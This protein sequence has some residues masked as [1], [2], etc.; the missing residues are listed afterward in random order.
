M[1]EQTAKS[2]I[3]NRIK[4]GKPFPKTLPNVPEYQWEGDP[5]QNFIDR[6]TS[7]DGKI[8]K[9]KTKKGVFEWLDEQPLFDRGEHKIYST[10]NEFTGNF[11]EDD[12]T[13]LRNAHK[14]ETCL[15]E[16]LMG[17]GE[18]G[19]IWVTDQS[20]GHA[21]CALLCRRLYILLDSNNVIGGMHEAY[22]KLKL[23][24][25]QY[26]CFFTGPS[27]TADIEAVHITGAQGT[28]AMTVLL[29]NCQ[30]ASIPP[31]IIVNPEADESV[32]TKEEMNEY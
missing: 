25:H 8:I 17:V 20:L 28:L 16:G 9:F 13:D 11:T 27:A 24:E 10:L 15:T 32:W 19:A 4:A 21:V 29:Y 14:I 1:N 23:N 2:N 7:F 5:V 3:I 12:L 6:L 26:G 18:M 30:D 31:K 22:T